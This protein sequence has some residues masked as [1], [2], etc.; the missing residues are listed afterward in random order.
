MRS[1]SAEFVSPIVLIPP[2]CLRRACTPVNNDDCDDYK[3][4]SLDSKRKMRIEIARIAASP[5]PFLSRRLP[6]IDGWDM[7][8]LPSRDAPT[9][10]VSDEPILGVT[11]AS[12]FTFNTRNGNTSDRSHRH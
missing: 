8:H 10:G 4:R 9:E 5:I 6:H 1:A 12:S 11:L 7:C 2:E 3:N